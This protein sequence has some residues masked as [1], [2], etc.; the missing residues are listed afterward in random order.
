MPYKDPAKQK[1]WREKN[2]EKKHECQTKYKE[3][4]KKHA[5]DSISSG[6]I[7]NQHKWDMWCNEIKR[8]AENNKH[9]YSDD[10]TNDVVFEMMTRGCFY[11]GD[12]AMTND[13]IDSKLDHIP[14]NCVASCYSCN[15]SKGT[16]DPLTFV[17]KAYY[18]ARGVYVD[19]DINIW[20]V[21]KQK[22]HMSS[23]RRIAEKKGVPFELSKKDW[24]VFIKGNCEYCK[25]SPT[26]WFGVDRVIPSLGY[27]LDNV[28]TC[29][30][31]CNLDKLEG[32][33]ETMVARNGRI[34]SRVFAG[35]HD[36]KE[37][38]KVILHHGTQKLSKK[39][40]VYG[41]VYDSKIEASRAIGKSDNYVCQCIRDGRYSDDILEIPM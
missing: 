26:T 20:F 28:V 41:N 10:F 27:V 32:D 36:I 6:E 12:I 7:I 25:R 17:K 22:P 18:R 4:L 37:C 31:D 8:N 38:D 33:V 5:Y 9:S 40:C 3:N 24:D 34:A 21:N 30:Y 2:K 19:D 23:Y 13:R 11:C 15:S 14:D 39:V 1:E 29:C 16:A 35:D